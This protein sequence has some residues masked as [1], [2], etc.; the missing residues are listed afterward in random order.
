MQQNNDE[1]AETYG[2][3]EYRERSQ[4]PDESVP[5]EQPPVARRDFIRKATQLGLSAGLS[6]FLLVGGKPQRVFA[7]ADE[8]PDSHASADICEPTDSNPD[9]CQT[10]TLTSDW[11]SCIEN[12]PDEC[13]NVG[14]PP[15]YPTSGDQCPGCQGD[16]D[17]C[18]PDN[19]VPLD[20]DDM[21]GT[22]ETA[23][24]ECAVKA[25]TTSDPPVEAGDL[26]NEGFQA[27]DICMAWS[28]SY[29]G[30][31]CDGRYYANADMCTHTCPDTEHDNG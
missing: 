29:Y 5:A 17:Q 6:H 19:S 26:C 27:P 25:G 16:A 22:V 3:S 10:P 12:D 2:V 11:D 15:Q 1:K 8:C 18:F 30:D 14:N 28:I 4:R 20:M 21:C 7:A 23:P 24:D 9:K 31:T 13:L